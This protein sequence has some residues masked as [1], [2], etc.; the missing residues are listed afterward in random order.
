MSGTMA[1]GNLILGA[2]IL[3]AG[4][5]PI[6]ALNMLTCSGIA[7]F[8]DRTCAKYHVSVDFASG[9]AKR[10]DETG[11]RPYEETAK[12]VG[13]KML[14]K[15]IGKLSPAQ[16]TSWLE[17]FH[18]VVCHFAP[19]FVHYEHPQMEA[20]LCL[21]ALHFNENANRAQATK[22]DGTPQYS[23]LFQRGR[24]TGV[25]KEVKVE[26]TYDYVRELMAEVLLTHEV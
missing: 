5:S 22:K 25:A 20:R 13:S 18:K 2:A 6:K 4:L 23:V 24:E 26:M 7:S 19:K 8:C 16:Q 12:I 14:L 21:A 1:L 9:S 11:F 17:A 10:S 15:D 3:L